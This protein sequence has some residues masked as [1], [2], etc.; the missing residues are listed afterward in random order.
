M[1]EILPVGEIPRKLLLGMASGLREVY[2]SLNED[3]FIQ[4]KIEAPTDAF[5]SKRGQYRSDLI[6]DYIGRKMVGE[7]K[8][9]AVTNV[10]I[11]VPHLNFVFGQA[12]L[13]GRTALVSICRLDPTFY[14]LPPNYELLLERAIKESV[15]ELGHVFGLQH[16]PKKICVMAFS[17]SIFEVDRKTKNFCNCCMLN[18]KH[19]L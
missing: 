8:I 1:I 17:N 9:L 5:D 7:N 12:Q 10:D 16:C 3:F 2:G 13:S 6:L 15:H 4:S 11:F 19:L 18:L 14:K